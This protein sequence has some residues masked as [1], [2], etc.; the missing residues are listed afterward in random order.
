MLV[1]VVI[2]LVWFAAVMLVIGPKQTMA[3][4]F[5]VIT[6][7]LLFFMFFLSFPVG[8]FFLLFWGFLVYSVYYY[9]PGLK[10]PD[11]NEE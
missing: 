8:L 4:I 1:N 6:F 3:F 7:A 5:A 10:L 9:F 2:A 11:P